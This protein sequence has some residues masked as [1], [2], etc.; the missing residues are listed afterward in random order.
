MCDVLFHHFSQEASKGRKPTQFPQRCSTAFTDEGSH[1]WR[2]AR[3]ILPVKF[4]KGV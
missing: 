4:Y 2:G 3:A 1:D